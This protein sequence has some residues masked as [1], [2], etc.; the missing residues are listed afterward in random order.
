M[1]S[2]YGSY[3]N[4][5]EAERR[6]QDEESRRA[7]DSMSESDTLRGFKAGIAPGRSTRTMAAAA[8]HLTFKAQHLATGAPHLAFEGAHSRLRRLIWRFRRN[9]RDCGASFGVSGATLATAALHLAGDAQRWRTRRC[10]WRLTRTT[11]DCGPAFG[12]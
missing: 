1:S 6:N 11:G 9:I 8:P 2:H 5:L 10:I 3:A 4:L 7:A 12:V